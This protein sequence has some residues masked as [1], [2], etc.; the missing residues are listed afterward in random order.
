MLGIR[1]SAFPKADLHEPILPVATN[2]YG[3]CL[4]RLLRIHPAAPVSLG[5]SFL[6][7][8]HPAAPMV[9][10]AGFVAHP[11]PGCN[12]GLGRLLRICPPA[13]MGAGASCCA[14]ARRSLWMLGR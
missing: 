3:E 2:T 11:P 6:L 12:G 13:T 7:R 8:I 14:S 4:G 9:A 1:P 5:K 10:W